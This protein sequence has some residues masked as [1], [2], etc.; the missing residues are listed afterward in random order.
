M[1]EYGST[2]AVRR[3]DIERRLPRGGWAE[4]TILRPK[5]KTGQE[6]GNQETED[7][8]AVE[9]APAEKKPARRPPRNRDAEAAEEAPAE[10][11]SRPRR[12]PPKPVLT[13][14]MGYLQKT[15]AEDV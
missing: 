1:A 5:R 9:E 14:P 15:A 3:W 8:E 12:R 7:V 10:E 6:E 2:D 13:K 11:K 4:T